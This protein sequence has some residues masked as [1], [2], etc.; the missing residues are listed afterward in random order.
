MLQVFNETEVSEILG[1]AIKSCG[2]WRIRSEMSKL[3]TGMHDIKSY[4]LKNILIRVGGISELDAAKIVNM[5][6]VDDQVNLEKFTAV[7]NI[8]MKHARDNSKP[9]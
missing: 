2:A 1:E 8:S 3:K 9:M 4:N 7:L 6:S 5:L